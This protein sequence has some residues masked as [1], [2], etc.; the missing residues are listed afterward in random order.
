MTVEKK[1]PD[2]ADPTVTAKWTV[3]GRDYK[4]PV[5]NPG[6]WFGLMHYHID[7]LRESEEHGSIIAIDVD[8]EGDDYSEPLSNGMEL[9]DEISAK[10]D[11][12]AR[13]LHIPKSELWRMLIGSFFIQGKL[14][15]VWHDTDNSR[16]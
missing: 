16:Q 1:S 7:I 15:C 12:A 8:V 13:R 4:A 14:R 9:T 10:A 6:D 3:D 2:P 11:E 5:I